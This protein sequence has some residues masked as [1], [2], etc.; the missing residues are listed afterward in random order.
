MEDKELFYKII[1][2]L[3]SNTFYA[4]NHWDGG[5][6][7]AKAIEIYKEANNRIKTAKDGKRKTT[8]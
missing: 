7:A 2:G 4:E 5:S 3:C 1:N 8:K 6:I